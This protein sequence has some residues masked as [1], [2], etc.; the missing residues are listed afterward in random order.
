MVASAKSSPADPLASLFAELYI[1]SGAAKLGLEPGQF[2]AILQAVGAKYLGAKQTASAVAA[3]YRGLRIEE[4]ALARACAAGH[5]RAWEVFLTR[6]RAR[7]YEAALA[8]ARND[9]IGR[10]LAD[11][12]YADLYGTIVRD[13]RRV[14]KLDFYTGRGSLEGWLRSVLAQEFIN[15]YR[16]H[17]R[18]VSL[19]EQQEEDGVQF[20]APSPSNGDAAVAD[21]RVNAAVDGALGALESEDRT[22][23]AAYYLDGRKLAEIG[24][25]LGVH[26]SS[27]SRRLDRITARLQRD[28]LQRLARAGMS[29]RQAE[30][31]L[32]CDVRDLTVDVRARLEARRQQSATGP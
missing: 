27:I 8:I 25:M 30:E 3:F 15:R 1:Q 24:R 6:Y 10:E 9:S 13:G 28:I 18:L 19:D 26:E 20:A 14:S 11:S 32:E 22:L 29:R 23:L 17:R 31:A 2:E 12:L 7:L 21:G 5:E 4:L 16:S